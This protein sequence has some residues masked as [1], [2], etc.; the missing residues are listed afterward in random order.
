MGKIKGRETLRQHWGSRH[1]L[2]LF[3]SV[4]ES[5]TGDDVP[6]GGLIDWITSATLV[7]AEDTPSKQISHTASAVV[8]R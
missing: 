1:G 8:I 5:P 2:C 3:S 4:F 6:T 7:A